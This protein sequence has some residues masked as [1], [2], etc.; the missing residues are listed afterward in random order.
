M[1]DPYFDCTFFEW[2][3]VVFQRVFSFSYSILFPDEVQVII[4][5]LFAISSS[6]LGVFLVFNRLTMIA[7]ALSHSLILGVVLACILCAPLFPSDLL[8]SLFSICVAIATVVGIQ[9]LAH[10][11]YI[12]EDA[13]NGMVFSLFCALGVILLSVWSKNANA[14]PELLIGDPESLLP[15][16]IPFVLFSTLGSLFIVCVLFRGI[17]TTTF[18]RSFSVLSGFRPQLLHWLFLLTVSLTLVSAF[19]AVGFVVTLSFFVIPPLIARRLTNHVW[20]MVLLSGGIGITAVGVGLA[21]SRHLVTV[22]DLPVST[23]AFI[24]V[25]LSI[26]YAICIL[27]THWLRSRRTFFVATSPALPQ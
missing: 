27:A 8:L 3:W 21:L 6:I 1:V 24:P 22:Y 11:R 20:K 15:R 23:S 16:D 17:V 5:S 4:L 14:G 19:R 7:N 10:L 9:S 26:L 18:D 12:H 25:L 13:S 2:F